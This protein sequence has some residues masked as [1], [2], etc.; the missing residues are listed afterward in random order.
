[1]TLDSDRL[2]PNHALRS[3]I[4]QWLAGP[5]A[6]SSDETPSSSPA[7]LRAPAPPVRPPS[8]P[9]SSPV[10]DCEFP[11]LLALA[12]AR[13]SAGLVEAAE[14]SVPPPPAR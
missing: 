12:A 1:M 13:G 7:P 2:S 8:P 5:G 9:P 11:A 3:A 10:T 4:S 14:V 6:A